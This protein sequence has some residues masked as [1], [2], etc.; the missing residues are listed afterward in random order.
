MIAWVTEWLRA[1][2]QQ[3]VKICDPYFGPD[4]LW[5]LQA[6]PTDLDVKIISAGTRLGIEHRIDLGNKKPDREKQKRDREKVKSMLRQAWDDLS[7]QTPPSTLVVVHGAVYD[8]ER[9]DEFHDRFITT[10]GAGLSLGTSLNGFGNKEFFITILTPEDVQYIDETYID[11]KLEI[12]EIFS[13]VIYF[14]LE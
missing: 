1:N 5:I 12:G 11:P 10:V 8:S 2:A 4:Q 7:T 14:E 9:G 6:I 3:Y 13:K